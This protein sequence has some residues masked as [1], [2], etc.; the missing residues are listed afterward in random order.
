MNEKGEPVY[1]KQMADLVQPERNT[2]YVDMVDVHRHSATLAQAIELQF[3]RYSFRSL[4]NST[5]TT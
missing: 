3:Y 2:I 4:F 1:Q 5:D